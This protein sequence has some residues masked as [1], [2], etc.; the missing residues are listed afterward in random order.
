[1]REVDHK[2][3]VTNEAYP[4]DMLG[5]LQGVPDWLHNFSG[6]PLALVFGCGPSLCNMPMSFWPAAKA[7]LSCGVNGFPLL[8]PVMEAGFVPHVWVCIDAV[9]DLNK[10]ENYPGIRAMW[11]AKQP[12]DMPLRIVASVNR[13]STNS[14]LYMDYTADGTSQEQ[15]K[16]K[17]RRSSVQAA[18][19]WFINMVQPKRIAL[20]GVDYN[21]PGRAGGLPGN[22]SHQHGE[23]LE[24]VFG[25]MYDN[26][27]MLGTDIVNCSPGT[28]LQ[29]V[30]TADWE[31]VL[32]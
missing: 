2:R 31:D 1:M 3:L 15:G 29:A 25:E 14:D 24:R 8:R 32:K 5:L 20:F 9:R 4:A 30:P 26:A 19:H 10:P 21:G 18:V 23:K 22:V 28:G 27:K 7:F 6:T 17:Y 12:Q 13:G 16:A 11:D